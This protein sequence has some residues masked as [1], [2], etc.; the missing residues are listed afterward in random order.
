M[1]IGVIYSKSDPQQRETVSFVRKFVERRGILARIV[2][3]EKPVK[4][5]SIV[6][7]GRQLRDMRSGARS[8][9]SNT[10]P[11]AT[12]IARLLEEECWHL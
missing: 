9:D 1:E 3:Q 5:I 10:F 7:N 8:G 11:A 4:S 6:I 12:D 2:E